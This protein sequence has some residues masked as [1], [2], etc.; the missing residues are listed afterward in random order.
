MIYLPV[1][2]YALCPV[3]SGVILNFS[4]KCL[5]MPHATLVETGKCRKICEDEHR[6]SKIAHS[7]LLLFWIFIW[8]IWSLDFSINGARQKFLWT[9]LFTFFDLIFFHKIETANLL[10]D[11]MDLK[12]KTTKKP[13]F[14]RFVLFKSQVAGFILCRKIKLGFFW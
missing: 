14:D 11:F 2:I 12:K 5:I 3:L 1:Q 13:R 8:I 7:K 10:T 4:T 6:L 9:S